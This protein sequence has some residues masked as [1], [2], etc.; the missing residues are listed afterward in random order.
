M[1]DSSDHTIHLLYGYVT[2]NLE[3]AEAQALEQ[4]LQSSERNKR[5]FDH[6]TDP[7]YI[8]N[9]MQS[10]ESVDSQAVWNLLR[11]K[12]PGLPTSFEET[13]LLK[14]INPF[15]AAMASAAVLGI[16]IA[17]ML[18]PKQPEVREETQAAI[19]TPEYYVPPTLPPPMDTSKVNLRLSDDST[20]ALIL[21]YTGR[22]W[23]NENIEITQNDKLI[24]YQT[25]HRNTIHQS[26]SILH[27]LVTPLGIPFK[28]KLEDGS[29]AWLSPGSTLKYA[30]PFSNTQRI[31]DLSGEAY[32]EVVPDKN[33]P[34]R[35]RARGA[36]CQALG[37]KFRV[38]AYPNNKTLVTTVVEGSVKVR[39]ENDST[40][41]KGG[42]E[43]RLNEYDKW[44]IKKSPQA[45]KIINEMKGTF[46]FTKA[47]LQDIEPY[48][49]QWH[50]YT[51]NFTEPYKG[52]GSLTGMLDLSDS[53]GLVATILHTTFKV[54]IDIDTSHKKLNIRPINH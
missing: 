45:D 34:F 13:S 12:L 52:N 36:I 46:R 29:K 26:T 11:Q 6:I 5:V 19:A 16:F 49:K 25:K 43:A 33:K 21:H 9:E 48:L 15:W 18:W 2:N 22:I 51:L 31:L 41:V 32:F 30:V 4:W 14:R 53:L 54:K 28:V 39:S 27:R 7:K 8:L 37:T 38:Q 35:I 50:G 17:I 40:I 1:P 42:Y 20:L 24:T 10:Q 47:S 23:E 44:D 3:P